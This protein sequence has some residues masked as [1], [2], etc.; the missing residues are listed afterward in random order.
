MVIDWEAEL[1]ILS[2]DIR[3]SWVAEPGPHYTEDDSG[4]PEVVGLVPPFT[5]HDTQIQYGGITNAAREHL[6][7]LP[8]EWNLGM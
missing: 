6:Q 1:D 8:I 2:N 7:T 5:H 3:E 4:V